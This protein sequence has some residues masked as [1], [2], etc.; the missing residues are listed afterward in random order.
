M[1]AAGA[2][3]RCEGCSCEEGLRRVTR[4]VPDHTRTAEGLQ[5]AS[6]KDGMAS[7]GSV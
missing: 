7:N 5:T 3:P 4:S 1:P 6:G 2:R